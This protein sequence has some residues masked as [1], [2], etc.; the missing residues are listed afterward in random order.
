VPLKLLDPTLDVV[1][2]LLMLR[3]QV[4]LRDVI[5]SVLTLPAPIAELEVIN[6]EI[7]EDAPGDKNVVLDIRVRLKDGRQIDLEMQSTVP[8]GTRARFLYYWA[9]GFSDSLARGDDYTALRPCVSILWFKRALLNSPRFHSVF[10]LSEEHS[11]EV[12]SPELE[13]HV[14][15]LPK[16]QLA[17]ADRQA[18]LERWARF[19]G[20]KSIDELEKLAHEDDVMTTAKNALQ[21]LSM[22]PDALRIARDRETA[23]LMHRHLMASSFEAGLAEGRGEGRAEGRSEGEIAGIRL[24]IESLCRILG[25]AIEQD[26]AAKLTTLSAEQLRQLLGA[27]ETDRRWPE[28]F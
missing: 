23:V 16:L 9:R 8:P 28:K 17:M 27:I 24:A 7:P 25:I 14:L 15:E 5:E 11:H 4:L 10:H 3:N 2:K 12:F 18:K 1:F 21:D 13:F 20:A 6:P 26:R 22:D 19:L